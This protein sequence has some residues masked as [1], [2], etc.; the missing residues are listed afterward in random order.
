MQNIKNPRNLCSGSVRQLN[1][2]ITAQRNVKFYAFTLVRAE[3]VDFHNSRK[4]QLDWLE[5]QGFDVVEH[6]LVTREELDEKVAF[7]QK[8]RR[9]DFR[10]MVW[11]LYMMTLR[12]GSRLGER[13]NSHEILCFQMGR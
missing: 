3:N 10:Q 9:N 6:Y 7:L 5:H 13:Q 12:M 8:D 11:F 4:E 1:N 2:K